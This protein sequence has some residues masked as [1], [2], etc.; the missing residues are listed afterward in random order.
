MQI[1]N[2]DDK[3]PTADELVQTEAQFYQWIIF[4]GVLGFISGSLD[5]DK[6]S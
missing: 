2:P 6:G 4:L 5:Y 1:K 3:F